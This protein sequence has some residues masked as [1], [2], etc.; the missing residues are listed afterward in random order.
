[1]NPRLQNTIYKSEELYNRKKTSKTATLLILR[2]IE[3]AMLLDIYNKN[4]YF[5][6]ALNI[7]KENLNSLTKLYEVYI[8]IEL[9]KYE[10]ADIILKQLKSFKGWYM[11]ERPKEY[12]LMLMLLAKNEFE[13]GHKIRAKRYYRAFSEQINYI[14]NNVVFKLLQLTLIENYM[15]NETTNNI[16]FDILKRGSRSPLFYSRFYLIFLNNNINDINVSRSIRWSIIHRVHNLDNQAVLQRVQSYFKQNMEIANNCVD[17][18][19]SIYNKSKASESLDL[20]CRVYINTNKFD[21]NALKIYIE[22]KKC[23]DGIENLDYA[24]LLAAYKNNYE[25]LESKAI[26]KITTS[27]ELEDNLKAFVYHLILTKENMK[28]M[29]PVNQYKIL[30]FGK[31][32]FKNNLIN[33]Y[34]ISIYIFM[35]KESPNNIKLRNYIFEKLF[36]YEIKVL[37]PDI[38]YIWITEKEKKNTQSYTVKEDSVI[39]NASNP[40]FNIYCVGAKQKRFYDIENNIIITKLL[41]TDE[42]VYNYFLN[43]KLISTELIITL[44]KAYLNQKN[45]NKNNISILKKALELDELSDEFKIKISE[46]LGGYFASLNQYDKASG[47]FS[48]IK[49]NEFENEIN[50]AIITFLDIDDIDTAFQIYNSKKRL[51]SD[52]V[53]LLLCLYCINREIYQQQIAYI[54]FELIL[55]GRSEKE[56]LQNVLDYYQGTIYNWIKIIKMFEALNLDTLVLKEKILM[57]SLYTHQVDEFAQDTFVDIYENTSNNIINK[58]VKYIVY[59][60]LSDRQ[61][62]KQE[63]LNCLENEYLYSQD[64]ILGYAISSVYIMNN[65]EINNYRYDIIKKAINS[66]EQQQIMFPIFK[67][68][69][70]KN[71]EFSYLEKN[72]PF[73]YNGLKDKEIYLNYKL[74][75]EFVWH[76]RKMNY[77]KFGMYIAVVTMFYNEVLEYYIEDT[78]ISSVNEKYEFKNKS[79]FKLNQNIN[80]EY[81][82]I[83]N[84]VIYSETL[85]FTELEKLVEEHQIKMNYIKTLGQTL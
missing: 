21:N 36:A 43:K 63:L 26:Q 48:I 31:E 83:N 78:S 45:L 8:D 66:M 44:S 56:L 59:M 24:Y 30:N 29:L 15:S 53:K 57:Q 69:K 19:E 5:Q 60:I 79:N 85:K 2:Y 27:I 33:K 6:K 52:R 1:M 7:I 75:E 70:D 23:L 82:Y 41:E 64:D 17:I 28:Y 12:A 71:N 20:L 55:K 42:N 46:K 73:I 65:L 76:K 16:I 51:V 40:N 34:Y 37:N 61:N 9:G 32:A 35:F 84:A 47:Y 50:L 68:Y 67:E 54:S 39:I 14:K 81:Y 4:I 49:P 62:I 77:F 38:K 58:F 18:I 11:N 10:E 72:I 3:G 13:K 25:N 80:D 22:A 74:K